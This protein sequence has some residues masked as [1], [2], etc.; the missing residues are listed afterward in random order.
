MAMTTN[1]QPA[2]YDDFCECGHRE[3]MHL[4]ADMN[5]APCAAD[6]CSCDDYNERS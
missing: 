3:V 1:T 6:G 5:Y 4:E 2:G